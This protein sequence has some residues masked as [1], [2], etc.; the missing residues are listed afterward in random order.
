M[1]MRSERIVDNETLGAMGQNHGEE[2][3]LKAIRCKEM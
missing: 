1:T 2:G 3:K